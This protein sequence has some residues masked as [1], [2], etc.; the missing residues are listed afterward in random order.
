[1]KF[2]IAGLGSIGRRHL[3]NLLALGERDILLYRTRRSTLP[4]DELAGLPVETDLQAALAHRPDAVIIANPTALHLDVAIPAAQAGCHLLLE[5]PVSHSME[6]LDDLQSALQ[7]GG[8]QVL[9]GFQFRFHPGLQQVR[10]WLAEGAIGRPLS[11]RA[12]WGEYL[13]GWHPWEDYRQGY[14]AR[15]ELG[16]G[17][18]LTLCHPLDYLRDL[19]GDVSALWAFSAQLNDL[20]LSVEDTAEIGLRFASGVL[21]SVHLDYNQRPPS[22]HLEIIGSEGTIR[23][24]NQDGAARLYRGEQAEWEIHAPPAGFERNHLFLAQMQ[25]FLEV[26]HVQAQPRCTLEDGIKALQLALAAHTS[27]KQGIIVSLW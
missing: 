27:Q 10:R 23:W 4:D 15:P 5:K 7:R 20:E 22:H 18:I 9:V 1:M 13:P 24:D 12:H 3:R 25:H 16:G 11:V 2:L 26:I 21:G 17:V 6:R 14:S 19:L 8:G